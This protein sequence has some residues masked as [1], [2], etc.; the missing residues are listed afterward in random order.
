MFVG[1][2]L[3]DGGD[4][5]VPSLVHVHHQRQPE[6]SDSSTKKNM[7]LNPKN[8]NNKA[9]DPCRPKQSFFFFRKKK[10]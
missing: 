10:I 3:E 7:D 5:E 9:S 8:R 6:I 1:C 2:I 4:G